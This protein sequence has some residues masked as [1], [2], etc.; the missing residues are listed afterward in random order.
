MCVVACLGRFKVQHSFKEDISLFFSRLV[1]TKESFASQDGKGIGPF[2]QYAT[3]LRELDEL[4]AAQSEEA[5]RACPADADFREKVLE[6]VQG[7]RHIAAHVAILDESPSRSDLLQYAR[8]QVQN[9]CEDTV[10][11]WTKVYITDHMSTPEHASSQLKTSEPVMTAI[12]N[13]SAMRLVNLG[14]D[15]LCNFLPHAMSKINRVSYGLIHRSDIERWQ[16]TESAAQDGPVDLNLGPSRELL[17]VPF[18]GKDTPSRNSEFA[19]PEVLIGL[20][21]LAYR[22]EGLRRSDLLNIFKDLK[23]K[24]AAEKGPYAERP[25]QVLFRRWIASAQSALTKSMETLTKLYAA[26]GQSFEG[27]AKHK[28]LELGINACHRLYD[29]ASNDCIHLDRVHLDEDSQVETLHNALGKSAP[30]IVHYLHETVFPKCMQH[31][32]YKLAASGVDLGSDMLFATRLG[33]SGTPSNLL[34]LELR[35]CHFEPGSEAQIVRACT[36][37]KVMV[38]KEIPGRWS[39][40]RLLE[41]VRSSVGGGYNALIDTGALI[42]GLDN[43]QVCRAVLADP[44]PSHLEVA[45]F[46]N[47]RDEKMVIDREGVIIPLSRC[48]VSLS[49]RFTFYDQVHTTGM[50]IKQA[51]DA[52]AV[53][54]L[55]KDMT[56]RDHAQGVYRMRGLG[57]GQTI[58]VLVVDE[59]KELVAESVLPSWASGLRWK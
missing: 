14:K 38:V 22:Y 21:V 34:P 23:E 4:E 17:A 58:T 48:G 9:G 7:V 26:N 16:A 1:K 31:Q 59:V 8:K 50:D 18:T 51:I 13:A 19:H 28:E 44:C 54:T 11:D 49:R 36:D 33:F 6:A 39:V 32:N 37:P 27:T 29:T 35:P 57:K 41:E 52:R 45:V 25:K 5:V 12:F 24:F 55:G 30:V 53:C 3:M 10:W 15:W 40:A 56:L 46:L 47:S 20:T 42:T 43:E 2:W